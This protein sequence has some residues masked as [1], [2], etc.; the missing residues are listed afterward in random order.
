MKISAKAE[1]ACIAM[2]ELAARH[3]QRQPLSLKIIADTYEMSQ[4]FLMQIF[5][6]LRGARLVQSVRGATGGYQLTRDPELIHLAEIIEVV[7]GPTGESSALDALPRQPVVQILQGI[8][9]DVRQVERR[10][11]EGVTLADLV[12][13]TR[14]MGGGDYQI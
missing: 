5:L 12:R 1:Y 8:W 13:R 11:L 14:E 3:Q 6:Q 10:A 7:D 2:A 9:R 4:P